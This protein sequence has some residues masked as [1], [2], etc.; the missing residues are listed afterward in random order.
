[1]TPKPAGSPVRETE[2]E[3]S[4]RAPHAPWAEPAFHSLSSPYYKPSHYRLQAALRA[5]IN[6]NILPYALDWE[7]AGSAPRDAALAWARSGIAY[8]DVPSAYRPGWVGNPAGIPWEE[9]DAFHYLIMV[10]EGSRIEGGVGTSLEGASVIAAPPIIH[11]GSEEQKRK[12]LPGLFDWSTSF[13]L[14]VTEP[15]GGSD[16]AALTTTAEK[17]KTEDGKE[18][19]VVNGVK[20]WITGIPWATHMVTA[21]RTGPPGGQKAG[22]A[23]WVELEDVWV[24]AEN[25]IGRENEGLKMILTNFNR[26]RFTMAVGMNRKARTCL[27]HAFTYA[28]RR[29]TFGKPLIENQIIR[30]KIATMAREIEAHWAWLEQIAYHVQGSEKNWQDPN[31]AGRIAL[32][33]VQ[34]GRLVEMANREAQQIFGGASYQ[35]GGVGATVEQISRDLRML[36][37]GGGSEE[38]LEDLGVRQETALA[39]RKGWKL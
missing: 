29:E 8:S 9:L 19:Y 22:G 37:V 2:N 26:E 6:K 5:Y 11:W 36:V 28:C 7:A 14:G 4:S 20:K 21:V 35:R 31:I 1:M 25:L 30:H 23:S 32:I 39:T 38:I 33:K 13:A 17:T 3:T 18:W 16:V 24:P 27:A 10:D 34:G 15:R 12:S